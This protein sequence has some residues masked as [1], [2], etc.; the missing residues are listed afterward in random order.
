MLS[1]WEA[2]QP[3]RVENI[4]RSL[5]AVVPSHLGDLD[6]YDF[7]RLCADEGLEKL[8]LV[9]LTPRSINAMQPR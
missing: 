5:R 9:D 1:R 6:L 8:D 2:E 7:G 3:G 4:A